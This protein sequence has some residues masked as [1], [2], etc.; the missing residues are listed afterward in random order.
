MKFRVFA[1][2]FGLMLL[3][4]ATLSIKKKHLYRNNL[5]YPPYGSIKTDLVG[6]DEG[7]N[8]NTK[9]VKK[10]TK[11][12]RVQLN[13]AEK[14][15]FSSM[16]LEELKRKANSVKNEISIGISEIRAMNQRI[17]E[18][19]GLS[20]ELSPKYQRIS[21]VLIAKNIELQAIS[22]EMILKVRGEI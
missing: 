17:R 21:K 11:K 8:F 15:R 12:S 10:A 22:N 20:D 18:N 1:T 2:I 6:T 4:G 14:N 5:N 19:H 16:S 13:F 9:T 3:F 7:R